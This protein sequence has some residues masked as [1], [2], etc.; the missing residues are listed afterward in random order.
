M[1]PLCLSVL[2]LLFESFPGQLEAR[3]SCW[4]SVVCLLLILLCSLLLIV[5]HYCVRGASTASTTNL[6]QSRTRLVLNSAIMLSTNVVV[7]ARAG[8]VYNEG[9]YFLLYQQTK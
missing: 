3:A 2:L 4:C 7:L 8:R 5:D 1:L 9:T 6:H